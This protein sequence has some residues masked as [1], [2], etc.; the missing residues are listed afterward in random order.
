MNGYLY[1]GTER[2]G[3]CRTGPKQV[4]VFVAEER[5]PNEMIRAQET[6]NRSGFVTP[7]VH[8]LRTYLEKAEIN[9]VSYNKSQT[10]SYSPQESLFFG[11]ILTKSEGEYS[12]AK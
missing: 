11:N 7:F 4:L 8:Q 12:R 5:E 10:I 3:R 6:G 1:G 9:I 2:N